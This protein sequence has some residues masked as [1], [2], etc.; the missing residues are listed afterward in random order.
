M[1]YLIG[2]IGGTNVR[3]RIIAD[4]DRHSITP[5]DHRLPSAENASAVEAIGR[6]L[7]LLPEDI[8]GAIRGACLAVAGPV[9]DGRAKM[10]NLA[11]E[12]KES[13]IAREFRFEFVH[14]VNDFTAVARAVH[15]LPPTDLE[16]VRSGV[17]SKGTCLAIGPGTGLGQ[18]MFV[19]RDGVYE[20][21][22][23]EGGHVA[24]APIDAEQDLLLGFLRKRYARVSYEHLLSGRGLTN[25][26]R[27][28]CIQRGF[29][30]PIG[31]ADDAAAR[32]ALRAEAGEP[33]AIAALEMFWSLLGAY[34]GDAVLTYLARGG[35]FLAGGILPRLPLSIGREAFRRAFE[36]KDP[37]SALVADVP[38][39]L[40]VAEDVG[41]VGAKLLLVDRL[42]STPLTS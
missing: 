38:V 22:P 5:I 1:S 13:E 15:E 26:H 32:V 35:V 16:V 37:M 17:R 23:S 40:V 3:L 28:A 36:N 42:R 10:T 12:F 8:R 19:R 4:D 25:L 34:A 6:F 14:L 24:F 39:Q 29:S 9:H 41:L 27:F 31:P 11:W 30:D 21:F 18:V 7:E 2:D 33:A 20:S